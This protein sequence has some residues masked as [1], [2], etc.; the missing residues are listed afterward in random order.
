MRLLAPIRFKRDL[1]M[2]FRP[3][4]RLAATMILIGF[5]STA[6]LAYDK[7]VVFGDSY[8]DVGNIYLVTTG[9]GFPYPPAPNHY[10]GLFSNG[11]I[12]LEHLA[13]DWGLPLK[14]SLAGGTDYAVGGAELLKST[15][16]DGYTIPSMNIR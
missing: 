12:W 13:S 2:Q 16:I 5:G 8:N 1:R 3:F 11:P 7:I 9:L 6:A 10:A 15:K 14:P 4:L